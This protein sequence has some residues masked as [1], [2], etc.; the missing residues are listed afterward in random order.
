MTSLFVYYDVWLKHVNLFF[1]H[2]YLKS[3]LNKN[4]VLFFTS[5]FYKKGYAPMW[6]KANLILIF[7]FPCLNSSLLKLQ[8][9][10]EFE[11]LHGIF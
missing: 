1:C 8:L 4:R 3:M 9:Y 11:E 5:F 10:P 7:E 2:V 6:I